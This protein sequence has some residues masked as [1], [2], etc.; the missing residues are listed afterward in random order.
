[1]STII[2]KVCE[3]CGW[4]KSSVKQYYW[5]DDVAEIHINLTNHQAVQHEWK[6][7]ICADCCRDLRDLISKWIKERRPR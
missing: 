7:E 2:I 6:K 5:A 1:M 3:L 4:E